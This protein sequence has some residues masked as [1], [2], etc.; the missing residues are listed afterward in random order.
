MLSKIVTASFKQQAKMLP[1]LQ[2][3]FSTTSKSQYY[4]DLD[5]KYVVPYYPPIPIVIERGSRIHLWDTD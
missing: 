3:G 1:A 4:Q 2:R 5:D